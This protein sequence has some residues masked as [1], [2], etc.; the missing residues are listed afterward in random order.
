MSDRRDLIDSVFQATRCRQVAENSLSHM[1][2]MPPPRPP[3]SFLASLSHRPGS[4]RPQVTHSPGRGRRCRLNRPFAAQLRPGTANS[5]CPGCRDASVHGHAL[6]FRQKPSF[7]WPRISV[8]LSVL[9]V[10]MSPPFGK[11]GSAEQTLFDDLQQRQQQLDQQLREL[12]QNRPV[13]AV[14]FFRRRFHIEMP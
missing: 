7:K 6:P 8:L 11:S 14:T 1:G 2:G 4:S 9:A 10:R 3:K 5:F 12:D 13:V